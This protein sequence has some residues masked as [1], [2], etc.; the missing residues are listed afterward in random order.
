VFGP[1]AGTLKICFSLMFC[2][3]CFIPVLCFI[4]FGVSYACK[5]TG[6]GDDFIAYLNVMFN[7]RCLQ[8]FIFY[9]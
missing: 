6:N 8:F 2:S 3:P 9:V 7:G 5:R 1:E 4:H